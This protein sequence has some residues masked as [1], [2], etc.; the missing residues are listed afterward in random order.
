M[1]RIDDFLNNDETIKKELG[2]DFIKTF[3]ISK[4][5][6]F[7][8][9]SFIFILL[10]HISMYKLPLVV[11][12]IPLALMVIG[13]VPTYIKCTFTKYY[14]TNQKIIIETGIVGRDYDIVR[15]DRVLDINL[16]VSVLDTIFK[17]GCIKL[18]TANETE[19]VRLFDVRNPKKIIRDIQ[20]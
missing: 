1:K 15:L 18:C 4:P 11:F 9:I 3:L 20:I 17:T 2:P 19:P 8:I 6:V 12:A 13:F 14:I 5:V 10:V 16:D 7:S